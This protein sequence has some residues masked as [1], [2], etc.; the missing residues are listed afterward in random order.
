MS[1]A[2]PE[3]TITA[4]ATAPGQAGIGVVRVS[5]PFSSQIAEAM[6]GFCP[7]PRV[8]TYSSFLAT[9]G[10]VLDQGLALFF[11]GPKSFTGEDV[12]EL[13]GHGGPVVLDM[14]LSRV[15]ELGA[16]MAE[17]GEFT[18][19]AFLNDKLDLTQAEAISDL[20]SSSTRQAASGAMR[21]LQGDFSVH[22]NDL[23]SNVTKLRVYVEAAIDFPEEEVNFLADD[24]INTQLRKIIG[25]IQHLIKESNTGRLLSDGASVVLL[26]KPNAGKSSLMNRLTASEASIVTSMPGTTRDTVEQQLHLDGIPLQIT[27]TAGIRDSVDEIEAEGV[28]RALAAS[29]RA[30]VAIIVVDASLP[31]PA[32]DL[33]ELSGLTDIPSIVVYNKMDLVD[34]LSLPLEA[35]AV[36]AINGFG[37][38]SLTTAIKQKIGVETPVESGFTSRRRHVTALTEALNAAMKGREEFEASHSGELLAE[39]L[40]ECQIS[41]G[42]ISGEFTADDLLGEIFSSFCIG[43]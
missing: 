22:V 25:D 40:R 20:I 21:S 7:E 13:Q 41:L 14:V 28:R 26:G 18:K 27:D 15:L 39:E 3:D 2:Y 31:K 6:L 5:G 8:A 10:E 4:I 38:E 19:R 29:D 30:D 12:L 43:K 32:L 17:P 1:S 16:R 24:S 9:S 36:S 35:L 11:A 37:F 42:Q 34:D 23:I 33:Q